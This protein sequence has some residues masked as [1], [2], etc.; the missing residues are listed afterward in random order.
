MYP[1]VKKEMFWLW[2]NQKRNKGAHGS[3]CFLVSH[4]FSN[5]KKFLFMFKNF[6]FKFKIFF[7]KFKKISFHVQKHPKTIKNKK[8]ST[9]IK[10]DVVW[11]KKV[12]CWWIPLP[13]SSGRQISSPLP[14]VSLQ[15][16]LLYDPFTQR[17]TDLFIVN[18]FTVQNYHI[19][20][21]LIDWS[22]SFCIIC[23]FW[24]IIFW[25]DWLIDFIR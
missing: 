4:F 2:K 19:S 21:W 11:R 7:F 14:R 1:N 22:I 16:L 8:G 20:D 6:F 25:I 5:S 13:C 12:A 17:C 10:V 15:L 23:I 18:W 9:E 24:M 3:T